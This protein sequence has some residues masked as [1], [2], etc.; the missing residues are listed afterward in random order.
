MSQVHWI[1][2]K[3]ETVITE[4]DDVALEDKLNKLVDGERKY[5]VYRDIG[6]LTLKFIRSLSK[7]IFYSKCVGSTKYCALNSTVAVYT[8]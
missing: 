7:D 3:T 1:H 4:D 8:S 5:D 6:K 2:K